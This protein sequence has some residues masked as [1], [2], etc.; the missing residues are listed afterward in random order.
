MQRLL[1]TA[2]YDICRFPHAVDSDAAPAQR[3]VWRCLGS[4]IRSPLWLAELRYDFDA[5]VVLRL[6]QTIKLDCT[7]AQDFIITA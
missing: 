1:W 7:A 3:K 5:D 6:V 4:I 2:R